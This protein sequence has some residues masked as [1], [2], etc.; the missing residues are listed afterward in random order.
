MYRLILFTSFVI[1]CYLFYRLIDETILDDT[2]DPENLP[3]VKWPFINLQDEN[4]NNINMLCIRGPLEESKDQQFFKK[5]LQSGVKFVGC[6]SY[7]SFPQPCLNKH[8]NCHTSMEFEGK[9]YY[10]KKYVLGWLHPF[11]NSDKYIP[12]Q[13]PTLLLS[14]S[15]F[16][17]NMKLS[18][19]LNKSKVFDFIVYCPKDKNCKNGWNSHNKNWPLCEKL[20]KTLCDDFHQ[21]GILVG[22]DDCSLSIRN[23]D[24]LTVT[25]FLNYWDFIGKMAKS[26]YTLIPSYEDASPRTITESLT[27]NVPIFVNKDILGGWKYVDKQSGM[28]FSEST[29]KQEIQTF[30]SKLST[31]QP[32]TYFFDNYGIEKSGKQLRDFLKKINPKV[33]DCKIVQF[34]IS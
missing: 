25:G 28:F 2:I 5:C 26:K 24:K 9:P 12:K 11:R 34:P 19:E 6:S 33:T 16:G 10:D 22:R 32:R 30:L 13:V 21:K 15:D 23:K 17:D 31:Y 27:L 14:E 8:G 3:N 20:I 1:V 29:M 7:L 4:K 18:S